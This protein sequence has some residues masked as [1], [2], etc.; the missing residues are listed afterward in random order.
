M[1]EGFD[2]TKET[3]KAP[4]GHAL[5]SPSPWN[6]FAMELIDVHVAFGRQRVLKGVNLKLVPGTI[7]GLLGRNGAGKTT[8]IRT[9]VGLLKPDLG[10]AKIFDD[11]SFEASDD[12]RRRL[13]YVQQNFDALPWMSASN[14]LAL[15]GSFYPNWSKVLIQSYAQQWQLP[16][17]KPLR[18]LSEGQRR[19]V[20]ILMALGHRPQL[21][22][23]D[24]PIASLDPAARHEFLRTILQMNQEHGQTILFSSHI[25]TDIERV[26]ADVAFL[27]DGRMIYHGPLDELKESIQCI[28]LRS[29]AQM[30]VQK[31][32]GYI[33]SRIDGNRLQVWVHDWNED[34][35]AE[36]ELRIG[37]KVF[38]DN[39]GLEE[40]FLGITS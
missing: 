27:S 31:I 37:A 5:A 38:C 25:T 36:L 6:K 39:V 17:N 33:S 4:S 22:V 16:L 24:E 32:D 13:G 28:Y 3:P 18:K 14:A 12:S 7:T 23:L 2:T 15:V 30:E 11:R 10:I 40:L 9:A 35:N 8:L 26:A 34:K 19:K 21:L 20:G 29:D 1:N